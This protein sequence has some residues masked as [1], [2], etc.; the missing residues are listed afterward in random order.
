MSSWT[1]SGKAVSTVINR[2]LAGELQDVA[3]EAFSG[4]NI[5]RGMKKEER[6]KAGE[7]PKHRTVKELHESEDAD[8]YVR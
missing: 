6:I 2:E 5:K 4:L 1:L 7:K 8:G 3:A